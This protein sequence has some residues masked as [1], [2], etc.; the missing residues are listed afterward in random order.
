MESNEINVEY[1]VDDVP[2]VPAPEKKPVIKKGW[3]IVTFVIIGICIVVYIIEFIM[4][5]GRSTEMDWQVLIKLGGKFNLL[6]QAGEYWRLVV[7]IFLHGDIFHLICNMYA[8]YVWGPMTEKLFGS[9]KFS[10]V[11]LLSGIAGFILS[12]AGGSMFSVA[13]GASG[14]IFGIFGAMLSF[15]RQYKLV[16]KR[17]IGPSL[18]L[19]IILNIVLGFTSQGI[20]NLGHIGGLIGG[21]L[22]AEAVGLNNDNSFKVRKLIFGAV[23]VLLAAAG[24]IYGN[25][26]VI[27]YDWSSLI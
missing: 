4:G 3:P 9:L 21:Y 16:Y 12:Y 18:F 25:Y 5:L 17:L 2:V 22:A 26:R 13:I 11:F 19:I 1:S 23:F 7:P 15:R 27:Y 8:L 10:I 14:A 20:D 24:I 6:V